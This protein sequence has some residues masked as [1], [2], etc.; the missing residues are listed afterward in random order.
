PPPTTSGTTVLKIVL[1]VIAAMVLIGVIVAGAIGIGVYK[2]AKSAHKDSSGNVSITTPDG[3]ITT[4]Q[5]NNVSAADLGI[6]LYPAV[7][8]GQGSM[9]MRTPEGS[10]VTAVY[11]SSDPPDKIVAFYKERLG[12]KASV[13]KTSNGT[14]LSA[15][16]K[17]RDNIVITITPQGDSTKIAIVRV[18][19]NKTE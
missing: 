6:D 8:T 18:T 15:G 1:I 17:D 5:N 7:T 9:N 3:T 4:G 16:E 14:V 12:D 13:V 2:I 10:M 19:S 11:L